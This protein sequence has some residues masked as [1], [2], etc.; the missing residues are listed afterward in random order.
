M[1]IYLFVCYFYVVSDVDIAVS[2]V[3]F[4]EVTINYQS[5]R[6]HRLYCLQFC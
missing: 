3:L 4:A 5:F 1:S 2:E 6:L